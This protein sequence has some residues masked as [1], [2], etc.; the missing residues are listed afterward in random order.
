M[1]ENEVTAIVIKRP[2]KILHF[3]DGVLEIFDDEE[4]IKKEIKEEIVEVDEVS[5]EIDV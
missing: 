3:S 2:S 1:E 5:D 4:E